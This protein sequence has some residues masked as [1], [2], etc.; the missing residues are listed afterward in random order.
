MTE[1]LLIAAHGSHLNPGSSRPAF[2]HADRIRARGAFAEVRE[3]FWKEEP[4]FREALRTVASDEVYVV[5]LFVSEGYFTEQVI[6]REFRLEGWDPDQWGSDGTSATHTSLTAA[7]AGALAGYE[8]TPDDIAQRWSPNRT[9]SHPFLA[10][11][12][13]SPVQEAIAA[14]RKMRDFWAGSWILHYLSARV[15]WALAQKYGPDCL[16]YPS[17]YQQP[18][19]D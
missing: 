4:A 5:P 13:F 14:S 3:T 12:S 9:L 2:D 17:L 19:I 15:S 11:F 18:L 10:S 8:L 1:A 16:V 6:P 7:L